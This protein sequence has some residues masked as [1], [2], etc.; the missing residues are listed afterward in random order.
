[1]IN[2]LGLSRAIG[3]LS[4]GL[5]S[6]LAFRILREQ[7]VDVE[8][9][10]FTTPFFGATSAHAAAA[11][12]GVTLEVRDITAVHLAMLRAPRYGYGSGLNPCIDCHA[13]MLR[14]AGDLM[15]ERGLDFIFTGEVLGQR[16]M[17]QS[18]GS[19]QLVARLSGYE[20][21]ILRPLS[22]RLLEETRPERE[23]KVERERLLALSGRGRKPQIELARRLGIT[24]YPE[25]AGGCLLTDPI[26]AG[27]LKAVLAEF[28]D[29]L[30]RLIELLKAGR[31]FRPAPGIRLVVGRHQR[32]NE[33]LAELFRPEEGD[34][35]LLC[36]EN[37][38]GPSALV[39]GAGE[40]AAKDLLELAAVVCLSY[41]DAPAAALGRVEVTGRGQAFGLEVR[42]RPRADFQAIMV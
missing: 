19:L 9:L 40:A 10:A 11:R 1:M 17:S 24:D 41:S 22:A 23:G 32:D 25:P 7:G 21:F 26:F 13:L 15:T 14:L 5:D 30:P 37:F 36:G 4:G 12:L 28:G 33:R 16:P 27:R 8:C 35:L 3:L 39:Y 42:S 34:W 20:G 38:P 2:P 18:R 29:L 31:Q 6:I